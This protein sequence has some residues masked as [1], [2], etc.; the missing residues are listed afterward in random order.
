MYRA[1]FTSLSTTVSGFELFQAQ[2]QSA[3]PPA[4]AVVVFFYLV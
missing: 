2:S 4:T 1:S 3:N